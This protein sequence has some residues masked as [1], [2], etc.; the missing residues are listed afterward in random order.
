M[1]VEDGRKISLR[2]KGVKRVK[3]HKGCGGSEISLRQVD[4]CLLLT[5]L[6]TI[7]SNIRRFRTAPR[8]VGIFLLLGHFVSAQADLTLP[9]VPKHERR[10]KEPLPPQA[11]SV[12]ARV[13]PG[14]TVQIP[15][16]I[17]G[18]QGEDVTFS[19]R[20]QPQLGSVV[21]IKAVDLEMSILTYR[22]TAPMTTGGDLHDRFTFVAQD[23]NGTSA[24]ADIDVAIVDNPPELAA[25]NAV[26]LGNVAVGTTAN[27]TI[28]VG[29]RGGT[30][31]EGD[32]F[33]E[34]PWQI[35]PSHFRLG[36]HEN[37][38]FTISLPADSEQEFRGV[39]RYP[40]FP[41]R[42]T[43]LHA[44]AFV[45][46]R[47]APKA[48]DLMGSGTGAARSGT[49]TLSNDTDEERTVCISGNSR[50]DFPKEVVVPAR[51]SRAITLSL[52]PADAT[53]LDE[54]VEF[55]TGAT[56]QQVRVHALAIA[57]P[58]QPVPELSVEPKALEFGRLEAGR[59]KALP[60]HLANNTG[61]AVAMTIDA[62]PPFQVDRGSLALDA[63]KSADLALNI[64][65]A[66]PG[67][68]S[69]ILKIHVADREI[70]VP[71]SAEIV[72]RVVW[73]SGSASPLLLPSSSGSNSAASSQNL[74]NCVNRAGIT[75]VGDLLVDR[76]S[77]DTADLSWKPPAILRGTTALTY[78]LEV[79]RLT[80]E[81]TGAVGSV[82]TPIPGVEFA[83]VENRVRAHLAGIPP[84]IGVTLRVVAVGERGRES[85]PSGA[86]Q[87]FTRARPVIVTAQRVLLA[88][89]SLVTL[90][91]LW[92]RHQ[93]NQPLRKG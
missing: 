70:T 44:N 24:P 79:R 17:Y 71:L 15:L 84:G 57:Q 92:L 2:Q 41:A 68:V 23:K 48:L 83:K 85:D 30:V 3:R 26:D 14:G 64:Q 87:F 80:V 9:V 50:L 60:L 91:A 27:R 74:V 8:W 54:A 32:F 58:N 73:K 56:L 5:A 78:R 37:G 62:P 47:I 66:W 77:F 29:N 12:T 67:K 19:T 16:R 49:V 38:E 10:G 1:P 11:I 20:L 43:V 31:L 75:P 18:R 25:P 51:S 22:Q 65:A 93:M 36:R 6:L 21:E 76:V 4:D 52:P 81:P 34:A 90:A 72:S 35:Q 89:F 59:P 7:N 13:G 40:G 88:V 86:V 61:A 63:G 46:V 69:S 33:L 45:P 82:W 53:G 42:D 28:V 55:R 39:L